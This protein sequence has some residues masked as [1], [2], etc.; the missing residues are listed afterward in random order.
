MVPGYVPLDIKLETNKIIKDLSV[1]LQRNE[2]LNW[3]NHP[4]A[5][6][7][8]ALTACLKLRSAKTTM[9]I[10]KAVSPSFIK[11]MKDLAKEGMNKTEP[12]IIDTSIMRPMHLSGI[13]LQ[14]EKWQINQLKDA[15]QE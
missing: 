9:Q 1:N 6:M 5:Q 2:S 14:N 12:D 3:M 10:D 15:L 13:S 4:H 11:A 7:M 8:K